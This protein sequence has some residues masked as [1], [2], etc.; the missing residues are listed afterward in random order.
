MVKIADRTSNTTFVTSTDPSRITFR[1]NASDGD[2]ITIPYGVPERIVGINAED[3]NDAIASASVSGGTI[4]FGL[5]DDA[6]SAVGTDTDLVGD[7]ILRNQ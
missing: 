2:T 1:S 3:D 6:G 7:V 5:I 4:T